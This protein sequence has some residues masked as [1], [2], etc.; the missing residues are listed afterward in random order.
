MRIALINQMK[1]ELVINRNQ[2]ICLRREEKQ[3]CAHQNFIILGPDLKQ[4]N[5]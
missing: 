3:V 4:N 5:L 1:L 2:H